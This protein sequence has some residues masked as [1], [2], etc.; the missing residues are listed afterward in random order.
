MIEARG[1]TKRYGDKVAV[2]N[3]S[4]TVQ[5]GI[6]TGFLGPN[7]AGKSTTMRL[8]LGLDRP[9]KGQALVNGK[10]YT[11]AKAPLRAVGALL[12]SPSEVA[13]V[14]RAAGAAAAFT[15]LIPAPAPDTA[16][17]AV[18]NCHLMR[19][20]FTIVDL[21]EV[22]GCWTDADIDEALR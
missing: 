4:F 1:L 16:R 11:A 2:D 6:V 12:A 21:A 9:T 15:E 22:T 19:D 20:R 7:G 10:P 8:I 18:T 14:L 17:W 13:A 5:P 3:L